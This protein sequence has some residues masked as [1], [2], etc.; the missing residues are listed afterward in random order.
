MAV[1]STKKCHFCN[2]PLAGQKYV[3]VCKKC[4]TAWCDIHKKTNFKWDWLN[5]LD[6][7]RCPK[8]RVSLKGNYDVILDFGAPSTAPAG[9]K[10]MVQPVRKAETK[11]TTMSNNLKLL[12]GIIIGV[13]SLGILSLYIATKELSTSSEEPLT[14]VA[15]IAGIYLLCLIISIWAWMIKSDK[16]RGTSTQKRII[17][18]CLFVITFIC[19]G[20][21]IITISWLIVSSAIEVSRWEASSSSGAIIVGGLPIPLSGDSINYLTLI[22]MYIFLASVVIG[23]LRLF[24]GAFNT[25][26]KDF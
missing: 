13:S 7:E 11:I 9:N 2:K 16:V 14:F 23:L 10:A 4:G 6:K 12:L 24:I 17:R 20:V 15:I 5:G 19:I 21:P 18:A 3:W 26:K 25:I 22:G 8:C 1:S